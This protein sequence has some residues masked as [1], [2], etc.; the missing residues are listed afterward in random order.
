[1]KQTTSQRFT[2]SKLSQIAVDIL[3]L[4]LKTSTR[5]NIADCKSVAYL[6]PHSFT[7]LVSMVCTLGH[8]KLIFNT[9]LA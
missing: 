6:N 7:H 3:N 9:V 8:N 1:M 4:N 5:E 2:S